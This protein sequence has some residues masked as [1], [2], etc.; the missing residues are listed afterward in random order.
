MCF[1]KIT[2]KDGQ[3]CASLLEPGA[4]EIGLYGR[5]GFHLCETVAAPHPTIISLNFQLNFP[6]TL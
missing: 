2:V 3:T 1:L 4:F 6:Q 5:K